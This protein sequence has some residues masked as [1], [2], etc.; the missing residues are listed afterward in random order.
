VNAPAPTAAAA[1]AAAAAAPADPADPTS[2]VFVGIDVA[3]DQFQAAVLPAADDAPAPLAN[4][5]LDYDDRGVARLLDLLRPLAVDRVV[6]EATGGL[7]RRLA[8]ALV[9]AG[10]TVV[11][12]NPRQVRDFARALNLL[13][14]TDAVD[15]LALARY[16]K[17]IR[18]EPRPRASAA[19]AELGELV[20][21]RRQPV[22]MRT[23]E[24]NRPER[25][26]HAEVKRSL[27]K[28]VALLGRQ[29]AALEARVA[30]LVEADDDWR[31]K[32]DLPR[33]VP[34]VGPATS[35]ALVAELPELGTLNR[36]EVAALVGLAPF[37]FDSGRMRGARSIWG[38]RASVRT[39]LYM[40]TLSATR[41][42]P[43]VRAFY[44]RKLDEGKKTMVALV[45]AMR[46]FLTIPN[47]VVRGGVGWVDRASDA[48]TP[49]SA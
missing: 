21:R 43:A 3:K 37:N 33:G 18:P 6:L 29:I 41:H 31:A 44:R 35:H 23:A 38:G 48:A 7:E 22:A 26:G 30:D 40:A 25:A 12:V 34:G 2:R 27:R 10:L 32:A 45:A 19:R 46:K 9:D 11:V 28:V 17:P 42:N 8:A 1:A 20:A 36:R 39:S 47:A 49:H 24:L 4:V 13:A 14:K 16:A 5:A 15:A